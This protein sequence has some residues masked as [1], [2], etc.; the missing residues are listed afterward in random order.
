MDGIATN[1]PK[2]NVIPILALKIS[3]TA[4]A[5]GCGGTNP[6]IVIKAAITGNPTY[7]TGTPATTA[8]ENT[9]GIKTTIPVSKN[10]AIPTI[11]DVITEANWT[12]FS[13]NLLT[14][15]SAILCAPPVSVSNFPTAAPNI[16]TNIKDPAE[17]P[18]PFSTA[19]VAS[20]GVIPSSI[21]T[22]NEEIIN[23]V[24]ALKLKSIIKISSSTTPKITE[25][26]GTTIT[27]Y[28]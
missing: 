18:S 5:P 2:A 26:S 12:C 25:T 21:P 28:L 3:A 6:C 15:V 1:I 19:F 16:I 13:P 7:K 14:I 27:S 22:V 11:I 24:N 17:F 9:N 8:I 4:V 10:I 20:K 23:E